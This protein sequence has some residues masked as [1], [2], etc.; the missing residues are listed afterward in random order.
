MGTSGTLL[1]FLV[2]LPGRNLR[3]CLSSVPHPRYMVAL[4]PH[5][6][7]HLKNHGKNRYLTVEMKT[8]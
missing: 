2:A 5:W 6:L 8:Q 7:C 3:A 1:Y 4:F